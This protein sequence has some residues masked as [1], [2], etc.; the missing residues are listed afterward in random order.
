MTSSQTALA[1]IERQRI[2]TRNHP[3]ADHSTAVAAVAPF[4]HSPDPQLRT[5]AD[6]VLAQLRH[7]FA[8]A[9]V[10]NGRSARG[11][12]DRPV[13][14]VPDDLH[15]DCR[16]NFGRVATSAVYLAAIFVGGKGGR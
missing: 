6:D 3:D 10:S 15:C 7:S 1:A 5:I 16:A 8:N 12:L 13:L 11:E 9:A 4:R 2:T 14:D